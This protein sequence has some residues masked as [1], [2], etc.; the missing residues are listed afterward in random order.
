MKY[1]FFCFLFFTF[2]IT[3]VSAQQNHFLYFQTEAKQPFYVK[4]DNK[5]FS[6]SSSGYLVVPRLKEGSYKLT[7]GFPKN[8]W[9][10]Q[11]INYK[12]EKDAGYLLKS[13]S[14]KGWGLFDLQ[15][16]NVIIAD[17]EVANSP[18][19]E[20]EV[21][22]DNFSEMLAT[23]VNDSAIMQKDVVEK[24]GIK[25]SP[26]EKSGDSVKPVVLN[27]EVVQQPDAGG[28][29]L[30]SVITKNLQVKSKGGMEMIYL[31]E[32]NKNK[33]TIRIFM[34]VENV[35]EEKEHKLAAITKIVTKADTANSI[36]QPAEIKEENKAYSNNS[37]TQTE[38]I[39]IETGIDKNNMQ[40]EPVLNQAPASTYNNNDLK[41][42]DLKTDT[43]TILA[44]ED[45][46]EF[47]PAK[48]GMINSNCKQQA[49]EDDFLKLR[50]RMA[51]ENNDDDMI[52]VAKKIFR[53]KCFAT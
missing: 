38:P 5:V 25:E 35:E 31:D 18:K 16:L 49:T 42:N 3:P 7:F 45:K 33:D 4:L 11:T 36:T 32:Y 9:P 51:A 1:I 46:L 30:Y 8:E 48:A 24:T 14:D 17:Q 23:V 26:K 43:T 10:E 44:K 39:K 40:Q 22:K 29:V 27:K 19:A 41:K 12:L 34:P 50:K 21:K 13:F 28:R 20:P 52:N 15:S 6:S 53:T 2:F 37:I 47:L